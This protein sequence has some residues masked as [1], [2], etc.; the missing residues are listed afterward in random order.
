[1]TSGIFVYLIRVKSRSV[2]S[3]TT[4]RLF[5]D[6]A[7]T[8][9]R[10]ECEGE[11]EDTAIIRCL[12]TSRKLDG[13]KHVIVVKANSITNCDPE[14]FTRV[15]KGIV[16]AGKFDIFYLCRW[17]DSDPPSPNEQQTEATAS[18]GLVNPDG[19]QAVIFSPSGIDIVLGRT[20]MPDGRRFAFID[21]HLADCLTAEIGAGNISALCVSPALIEYDATILEGGP[22]DYRKHVASESSSPDPTTKDDDV[23]RSLGVLALVVTVIATLAWMG[24]T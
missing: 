13:S 24:R 8:L 6:P 12:Q 11:S 4:A 17:L 3:G 2:Q 7:F 21:G 10:V 1:M 5:S 18:A 23:T 22:E 9:T 20:R 15:V 14:T 19:L 16:S